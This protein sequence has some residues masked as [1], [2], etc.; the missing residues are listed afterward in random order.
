MVQDDEDELNALMV[1]STTMQQKYKRIQPNLTKKAK[2]M[3]EYNATLA[4]L[5]P[6]DK[7]V[8]QEKASSMLY[9]NFIALYQIELNIL[10]YL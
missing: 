8:T 6:E 2:Q 3:R 7:K 10:N 9:M 1:A 5:C 4:M